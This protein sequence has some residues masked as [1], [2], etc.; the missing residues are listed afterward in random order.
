[1]T[2]Y[3]RAYLDVGTVAHYLLKG[4]WVARCG[5]NKKGKSP[6]RGNASQAEIAYLLTLPDCRT[7]AT[8]L[9]WDRRKAEWARQTTPEGLYDR[10]A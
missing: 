6:W 9:E 10:W 2:E 3:H 8:Q 4:T 7:C 5:M 1:M